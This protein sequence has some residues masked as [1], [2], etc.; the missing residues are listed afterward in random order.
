MK[1]HREDF[2]TDILNY[3]KHDADPFGFEN[4]HYITDVADSKKL[5]SSSEACII[6]SSS[7]MAE[8]GRVKHHIAN[9]VENPAN[10]VLMVGY[11]SPNSL[12]YAL[13]SGEKTVQIFGLEKIVR[14]RI[15][16]MDSFS[17]H[18]DYSEMI[19]HLLCQDPAKV[20]QL[21]LVH[22]EIE[23]QTA[24]KEKLH[25]AGFP[26]VYIPNHKEKVSI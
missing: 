9:N 8:A 22:G 11:C 24:F 4:L 6:I 26:N 1:N 25:E 13:K 14:A 23:T 17:A 15:A 5:N 12:G 21:F 2:N 19:D 10:T 16:V 20:K 18:A 3:I 7:G